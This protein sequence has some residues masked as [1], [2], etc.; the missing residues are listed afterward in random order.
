MRNVKC[1]GGRVVKALVYLLFDAGIALHGFDSQLLHIFFSLP[2]WKFLNSFRSEYFPLKFSVKFYSYF[3][4]LISPWTPNAHISFTSSPKQREQLFP[5]AFSFTSKANKH[6][7]TTMTEATLN[8]VN[9]I[10]TT[11]M[12]VSVCCI[13]CFQVI[14]YLRSD[15]FS[16]DLGKMQLADG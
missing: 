3:C 14:K 9:I 7:T 15:F 4:E 12:V 10:T 8:R 5:L 2:P 1:D 6:A 16:F 11:G 13:V